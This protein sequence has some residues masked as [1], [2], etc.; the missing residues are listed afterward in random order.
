M[1][2]AMTLRT[3]LK[4]VCCSNC[5]TLSRPFGVTMKH[6][7]TAA[8]LKQ[9]ITETG[10]FAAVV[11]VEVNEKPVWV[12]P[13]TCEG[14]VSRLLQWHRL[15]CCFLHDVCKNPFRSP[16]PSPFH[17]R[18]NKICPFLTQQ[19]V[20]TYRLTIQ[21]PHSKDGCIPLSS[22]CCCIIFYPPPPLLLLLCS[23]PFISSEQAKARPYWFH[24]SPRP[25]AVPLPYHPL[26]S[27]CRP[28]NWRINISRGHYAPTGLQQDGVKP[29]K[30]HHRYD[31]QTDGRTDGPECSSAHHGFQIAFLYWWIS[32][33]EMKM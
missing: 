27:F 26:T 33:Y 13:E 10:I 21:L 5:S 4:A 12:N 32:I 25:L 15:P 2:F 19:Q 9:L 8:D 30:C 20:L 14:N 29:I 16:D 11:C 31:G 6:C 3:H 24:P 17:G 1:T 18:T 22:C 7:F 23:P 28:E